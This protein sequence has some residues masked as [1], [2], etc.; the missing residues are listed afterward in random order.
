MSDLI[1]ALLFLWLGVNLGFVGGAWWV[2][3]QRGGQFYD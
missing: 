1:L 3:T 2:C